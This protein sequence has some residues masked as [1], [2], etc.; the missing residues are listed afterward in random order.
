MERPSDDLP[1][2][3]KLP[4]KKSPLNVNIELEGAHDWRKMTRG[5]EPL[6]SIISSQTISSREF[7]SR[8]VEKRYSDLRVS[9]QVMVA[10]SGFVEGQAQI[11]DVADELL[12]DTIETGLRSADKFDSA[13]S[14]Y[15][16]LMGIAVNKL[17]E[18]RRD[19]KNEMK[20]VSVFDDLAPEGDDSVEQSGKEEVEDAT[21][22][23]RIDSALYRSTNRSTLEDKASSLD[24][25]LALVKEDEREIL[26]LAIVEGLSGADLAAAFGIR[27][28]AAYMRLARAQEHLREKYLSIQARKDY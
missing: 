11:N 6:P 25:M 16:W 17:R 15:S 9:V 26:R 22:E 18:M 1:L 2:V 8:E 10:R 20:R 4:V 28:G 13:R 12:N 5:P 27:E 24:E 21:A 19:A 23:E 14:V 3:S 7:I